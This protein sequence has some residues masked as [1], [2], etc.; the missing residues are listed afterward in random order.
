MSELKIGDTMI[1]QMEGAHSLLVKI[2]N[3]SMLKMAN[4]RLVDAAD[5]WS[6]YEEDTT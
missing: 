2:E 6:K 4:E 3:E 5:V 1:A